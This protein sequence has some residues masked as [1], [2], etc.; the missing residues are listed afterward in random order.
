M[1]DADVKWQHTPNDPS[2]TDA[3]LILIGEIVVIWG[4]M[5]AD[6]QHVIWGYLGDVGPIIGA[7]VSAGM[8]LE[9]KIRLIQGLSKQVCQY[10]SQTEEI[11]GLLHRIE[12]LKPVRNEIVHGFWIKAEP[13]TY[14]RA[15]KQQKELRTY[16]ADPICLREFRDESSRLSHELWNFAAFQKIFPD[17]DDAA[18]DAYSD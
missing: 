14:R 2:L 1:I 3:D 4:H 18:A 12:A 9:A 6:L 11:T 7:T 5:E 15:L 8:P 17:L 13:R 16:R 10:P